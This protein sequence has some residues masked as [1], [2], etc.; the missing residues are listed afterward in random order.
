MDSSRTPPAPPLVHCCNP[1][2]RFLA[3]VTSS[4]TFWVHLRQD[5]PRIRRDATRGKVRPAYRAT[6]PRRPAGGGRIPYA[7]WTI[8]HDRSRLGIRVVRSGSCFRW[9]VD[10]A[11]RTLLKKCLGN[12]PKWQKQAYR[13]G[14]AVHE[15]RRVFQ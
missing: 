14:K 10:K 6:V 2:P 12:V 8:G 7:F 15:L 9:G 11:A 4:H 13:W 5:L 1:K 3:S